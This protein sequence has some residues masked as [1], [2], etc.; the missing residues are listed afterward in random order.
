MSEGGGTTEMAL[1]GA[2]ATNTV[3]VLLLPS[4]S[5]RLTVNDWV[6]PASSA[7]GVHPLK[8]LFEELKVIP[9]GNVVPAAMVAESPVGALAT[10]VKVNAVPTVADAVVCVKLRSEKT[11][12]CGVA[13]ELAL[14]V[15]V[16]STWIALK[17]CSPLVSVAVPEVV[18]V[19]VVLPVATV[20][21]P[22]KALPVAASA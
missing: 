12:T 2:T 1:V 13:V 3:T 9:D 20:A 8:V 14:A 15:F 21:V 22:M 6:V 17:V 16:E 10:A 18:T 11:C 19:T 5:V 7:V 4:V